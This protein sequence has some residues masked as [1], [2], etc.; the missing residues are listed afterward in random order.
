MPVQPRTSVAVMENANRPAADGVPEICPVPAFNAS[1][2]SA[3]ALA[4]VGTM[5]FAFVDGKTGSMTYSLNGIQVIKQ[6]S[7]FEFSNP[8]PQCSSS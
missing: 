3:I 8:K 2:W 5:T 1:P 4:P 6:I 7:R